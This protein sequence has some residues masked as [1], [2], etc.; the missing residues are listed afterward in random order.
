MAK[1]QCLISIK[2]QEKKTSGA[3]VDAVT[4]FMTMKSEGILSKINANY[5]LT[6]H[7]WMQTRFGLAVSIPCMTRGIWSCVWNDDHYRTYLIYFC[8]LHLSVIEHRARLLLLAKLL[9]TIHFYL[10]VAFYQCWMK[11]LWLTVVLLFTA[12]HSGLL[13]TCRLFKVSYIS[14]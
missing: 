13:F 12:M 11:Y 1:G 6:S 14:W 4:S 3:T 8:R 2:V 5:L 9:W 7:L 10:D